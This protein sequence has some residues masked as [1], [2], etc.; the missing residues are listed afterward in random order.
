MDVSNYFKKK[1]EQYPTLEICKSLG[2][3]PCIG[4]TQIS[5]ASILDFLRSEKRVSEI[6]TVLNQDSA[7]IHDA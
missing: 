6:A 1:L 5:V 4:G 3:R 2:G 7:K